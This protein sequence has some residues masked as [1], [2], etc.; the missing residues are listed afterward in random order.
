MSLNFKIILS[1]SLIGLL[2]PAVALF[3]PADMAIQT[4]LVKALAVWMFGAIILTAI[5]IWRM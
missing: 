4:L 5:A 3:A 1:Y 2:I